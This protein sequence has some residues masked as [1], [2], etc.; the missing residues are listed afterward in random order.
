MLKTVL[1]A[2][3]LASAFALSAP[4]RAADSPFEVHVA[5]DKS[6]ALEPGET[7]T[8][9]I[10]VS[11][12]EEVESARVV[13]MLPASFEP[14]GAEPEG[15]PEGGQVVWEVPLEEDGEAVIRHTVAAGSAEQVES[16]RLVA[17]EQPGRPEPAEGS[18]QF[19]STVCVQEGAGGVRSCSSAWQRLEDE[20]RAGDGYRWFW[21]GLV[22]VFAAAAAAGAVFW[23]RRRASADG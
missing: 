18:L 3:A 21:V 9:T 19:S 23:W 17:V 20:Q 15:R 13:Q 2:G 12:P 16:G 8:Y 11:S 1:L 6:E 5:P 14:V 4:A 10:T 7:V 22:S